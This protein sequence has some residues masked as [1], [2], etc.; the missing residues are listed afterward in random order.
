MTDE[1]QD[2]LHDRDE[3]RGSDDDLGHGDDCS[4]D[5]GRDK[6]ITIIVNGREK[7]VTEREL[8]TDD[9]VK[10]AFEDPPT[11]EFICFTITYRRGQGNKPEGTLEEGETVKVKKGMIFNV[12]AT[13]KS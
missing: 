2:Q 6:A 1:Q 8:T 12:T 9:L 13:D 7:T 4:D 3:N 5:K 11:G 10:L